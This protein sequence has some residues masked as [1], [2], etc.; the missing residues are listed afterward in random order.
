MS[1]FESR[2]Q[3]TTGGDTADLEELVRAVVKWRMCELMIAL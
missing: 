2:Y 3:A 1:A